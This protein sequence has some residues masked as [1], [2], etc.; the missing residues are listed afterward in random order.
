MQ[1]NVEILTEIP[2]FKCL[3]WEPIKQSSLYCNPNE[4]QKLTEWLLKNA[5][6]SQQDEVSLKVVPKALISAKEK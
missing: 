2:C 3:F 1:A 4:C 6:N 5:E